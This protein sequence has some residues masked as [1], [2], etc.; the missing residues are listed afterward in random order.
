DQPFPSYTYVPGRAAH[1]FREQGGHS[2]GKQVPNVAPITDHNWPTHAMYLY[3]I[4]LFNYGYYWEAHE[5]WEAVW[6]ACG[7]SGPVADFLK[8]LIKLA[9][10]GVKLREDRL[11][12]VTR[13]A[14]RAA[15]LFTIAQ[16]S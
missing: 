12:G 13:H 7:R 1:P 9:A 14:S 15:Q 11:T 3:A 5:A 2:H 10:A 6:H 4:D 16:T 8:A